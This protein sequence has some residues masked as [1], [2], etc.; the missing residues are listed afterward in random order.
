M[1]LRAVA[2]GD[3]GDVV[4]RYLGVDGQA[5]APLDGTRHNG[6]FIVFADPDEHANE[7]IFLK[8]GA[9]A[10]GVDELVEEE[11]RHVGEGLVLLLG[12]EGEVSC[13]NEGVVALGR[14]SAGVVFGL[15]GEVLLGQDLVELRPDD[16]GLGE[17]RSIWAGGKR[18]EEWGVEVGVG[19]EE[20][21]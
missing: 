3:L 16:A 18:F 20:D 11:L 1:A 5:L 19:L 14:L 2:A 8:E 12:E 6:A 7:S 21:V 15:V 10:D 17:E 9:G 13:H 4:G